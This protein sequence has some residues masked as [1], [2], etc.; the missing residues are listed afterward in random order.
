MK[1]TFSISIIGFLIDRISKVIVS[2]NC[3]LYEK[4]KI[5]DNFFYITYVKNE[6]AAWSILEGNRTF[7]I[8]ISIFAIIF[9][10]KCIFKEENINKFE[11]ISYGVLLGGIIGNLFDRVFYGYV[12]DFFDFKF[13]SYSYPVFNI[14]DI[15][16]VVGVL[17]MVIT[18]IR[19]DKNEIGS[20]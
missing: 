10:L 14:A 7:L 16:I 15:L 8:L 3:L 4:N 9:I 20:K 5:I 17:I 18:L 6:G 11:S 1:K 12:I 13:F 2:N 19:G